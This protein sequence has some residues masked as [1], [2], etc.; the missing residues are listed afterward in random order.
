MPIGAVRESYSI[1][2]ETRP[3]FMLVVK[4]GS[5]SAEVKSAP[6]THKHAAA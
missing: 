5:I 2:V 3:S 1:S 4:R 6:R